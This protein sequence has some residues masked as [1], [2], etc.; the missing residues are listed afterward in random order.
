MFH[1]EMLHYVEE[2]SSSATFLPHIWPF[3]PYPSPC[4]CTPLSC[5]LSLCSCLPLFTLPPACAA[6]LS[7]SHVSWQQA[8][9][10]VTLVARC[11]RCTG[12]RPHQ[13]F[14]LH[15]STG[16]QSWHASWHYLF[17]LTLTPSGAQCPTR[18]VRQDY[19]ETEE[20]FPLYYIKTDT[21][22]NTPRPRDLF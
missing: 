21:D 19:T 18:T 12:G 4:L 10:L 5:A 2:A 17:P 7:P 1:T 11:S 22:S 3:S 6:S 14:L 20:I 9:V 15:P 16:L 8:A 13:T